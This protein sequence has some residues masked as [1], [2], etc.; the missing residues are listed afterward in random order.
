MIAQENL[1]TNEV[2]AQIYFFL[3]NTLPK[4]I[5][6]VLSYN[7]SLF[8]SDVFLTTTTATDFNLHGIGALKGRLII[9][10]I[11]MMASID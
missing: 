5:F 2:Y 6:N 3:V 9:K 8:S 4:A 7:D 10:D 1:E 11:P